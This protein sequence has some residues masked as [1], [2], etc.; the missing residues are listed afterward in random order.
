MPTP[1]R[2]ECPDCGWLGEYVHVRCTIWIEADQDDIKPGLRTMRTNVEQNMPDD[3]DGVFNMD[4]DAR[5]P[6]CEHEALLK[7]FYQGAP[8]AKKNR[9]ADS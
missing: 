4:S 2:I 6:D 1:T 7:D 3:S 8:Y 5:C 9:H